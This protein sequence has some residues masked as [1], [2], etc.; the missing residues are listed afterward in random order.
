GIRYFNFYGP[1]HEI[2]EISQMKK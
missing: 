1:N 2:I